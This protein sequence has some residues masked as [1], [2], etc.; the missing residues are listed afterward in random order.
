[1]MSRRVSCTFR[2][3]GRNVGRVFET[4]TIGIPLLSVRALDKPVNK[5]LITVAWTVLSCQAPSSP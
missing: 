5:N 4:R 2:P 1:M 3:V